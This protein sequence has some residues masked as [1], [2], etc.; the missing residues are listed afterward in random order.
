MGQ[1]SSVVREAVEHQ[2]ESEKEISA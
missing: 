2:P 1:P